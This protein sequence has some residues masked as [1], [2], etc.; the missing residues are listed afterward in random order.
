MVGN[1]QPAFNFALHSVE[2]FF[3]ADYS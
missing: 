2:T 3:V 1:F